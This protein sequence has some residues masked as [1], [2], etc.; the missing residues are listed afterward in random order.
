MP[1]SHKPRRRYV[2]KR[3]GIDETAAFSA[4]RRAADQQRTARAT[5]STERLAAA[6]SPAAPSCSGSRRC[7]TCTT[8]SSRAMTA[9]RGW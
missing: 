6:S 8:R 3:H 9:R 2:P 4:M 7:W 1:R 5:A